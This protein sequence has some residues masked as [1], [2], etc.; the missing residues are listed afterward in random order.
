MSYSKLQEVCTCD[1][2]AGAS[3]CHKCVNAAPGLL[4]YLFTCTGALPF[5]SEIMPAGCHTIRKG[6]SC[7][8]ES[9]PQRD[10]ENQTVLPRYWHIL[11]NII[12]PAGCHMIRKKGQNYPEAVAVAA[13]R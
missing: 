5:P 7:L 8:Q 4:D 9:L 12:M 3:S 13:E 11:R 6:R 1:S 2:P 10:E